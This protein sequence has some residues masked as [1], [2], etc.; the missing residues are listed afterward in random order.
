MTTDLFVTNFLFG[1]S[2]GFAAVA[3]SIEL[4]ILESLSIMV[5]HI[6]VQMPHTPFQSSSS[7]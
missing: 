2:F 3:R 5:L 7:T 4:R 6:V 1:R